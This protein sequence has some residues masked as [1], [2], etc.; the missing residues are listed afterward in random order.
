MKAPMESVPFHPTN[1]DV[2]CTKLRTWNTK[3]PGNLY[4]N[5]LVQEKVPSIKN[6]ADFRTVAEG[7]IEFVTIQKGTRFLK[8]SDKDFFAGRTPSHCS[9]M[10]RRQC[11]HKVIRSM[12]T[13]HA[14][15]HGNPPRRSK[16]KP[17]RKRATVYEAKQGERPIHPH[18]LQLIS[19]VCNSTQ[20]LSYRVLDKPGPEYTS[21]TEPEKH[22]LMRLQMRHRFASAKASKMSPIEFSKKLLE[23]WGG[24]LERVT[25]EVPTP[26]VASNEVRNDNSDCAPADKNIVQD[27]EA[28]KGSPFA[29][30]YQENQSPKEEILLS[31]SEFARSPTS[32]AAT[33]AVPTI[34]LPNELAHVTFPKT[35]SKNGRDE[36]ISDLSTPTETGNVE[37]KRV[38]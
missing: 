17:R 27:V 20:N 25:R 30:S 4:F 31:K 6:D 7:L 16:N 23:L 37:S 24:K 14:R 18:A 36:L 26:K 5:K 33:H 35:K 15:F 28:P 22:R 1:D 9:V 12:R 3:H 19:L 2:V 10:N 11:L 29:P 34:T 21:E 38:S 32:R 8:L 13:A